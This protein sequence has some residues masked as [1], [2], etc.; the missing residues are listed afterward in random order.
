MAKSSGKILIDHSPNARGKTVAS[1]YTPR[2]TADASVST[3][4]SWDELEAISASSYTIHNLLA[5]LA[6]TGDIWSDFYGQKRD[7]Q[8]LLNSISRK[9][10]F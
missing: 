6:D 5:R 8:V 1:A 10:T 2:A 9:K 4:V 3:P 7:L